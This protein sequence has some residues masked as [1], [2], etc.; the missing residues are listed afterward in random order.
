MRVLQT[1]SQS[2]WVVNAATVSIVLAINTFLTNKFTLKENNC[3]IWPLSMLYPI[4]STAKI[5]HTILSDTSNSTYFDQIEIEPLN[6]LLKIIYMTCFTFARCLLH[7]DVKSLVSQWCAHGSTPCVWNVTFQT[8]VWIYVRPTLWC[9]V[10]FQLIRNYFNTT[11]LFRLVINR[12]T[13][14]NGINASH[15]NYCKRIWFILHPSEGTTIY[16]DD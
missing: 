16:W 14:S 13:A 4:A 3:F 6:N 15:V 8:R 9:H 10:T 12:K 7:F 11:N 5:R 1:C 2:M